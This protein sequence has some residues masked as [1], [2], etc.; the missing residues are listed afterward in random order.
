MDIKRPAKSK[1]KKRIRV[2]VLVTLVLAAVGG[3]TYGLTKLHPAA[4][5]LDR[6]SAVIDTVKRGQMLLQVRGSGTLVPQDIRLLPAPADGRVEKVLNQAGI[7]V[8]PST[9][10]VTLSNPQM[11]Q[12]AIDA[13]FQVKAAVADMENLRV[14]LKSDDMTQRS[15]VASINADYSQ[16]KLQLDT[17]EA[18]GKEGLVPDLTLRLARVHTQDLADRLKVEQERLL[19]TAQSAKAQIN[20][21]QAHVDQLRALA[22]LK[23]Q[24]VEDLTVRAGTR[25]VLQEVLVQ[26]GQ[27]A[28]PG[29]NLARVA[30]PGSLKAQLKIAETQISGVKIGQPVE[31]DT[32]NGLI[33]ARVSRMDPAAQNGTVTV[34]AELTGPLPASARVDLTVDGTIELARLND[35]L[36]V[37]RPASGQAKSTIG[38]FKLEPNGQDA[39]RTQVVLGQASV[40]SIEIVSGLRE[41]DQVVLSDTAAVDS[42]NRILVR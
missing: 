27:Q 32:R 34:D 16:A 33:Q 24:Q 39:V 26:V 30:D 19:V 20:A 10:I 25:G 37:G 8:E 18:L 5:T 38:M 22:K 42:Y 11:E 23:R 9:V 7:E 21:Q 35:V 3:I 28:T 17:D 29:M 36:Y 6:S 13:D 31:V 41:G 15:A 40:S 1:I 2:A 14:R 12:Q 4:P